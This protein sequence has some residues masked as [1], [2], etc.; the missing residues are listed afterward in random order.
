MKR[1]VLVVLLLL[2]ARSEAAVL[3]VVGG[4]LLGASSV[5]IDGV[6]YDV[7][8]VDG[9]CPDLFSGCDAASDFG[10]SSS[11]TAVLFA[12]ALRDQI[13]IDG[14]QGSFDSDP[15]LVAGCGTGEDQC[16][17]IIPYGVDSANSLGVWFYNNAS[18]ADTILTGPASTPFG[19]ETGDPFG[20]GITWARWTLHATPAVP[21]VS[22]AASLA[23]LALLAASGA[24]AM[25]SAR[26]A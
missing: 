15:G 7:E 2:A 21:S 26:R 25:R 24:W 4:Q 20:D 8:F 13:L 12:E 18:S 14:P 10:T 19:F 22:P 5:D 23:L 17:F 1:V 9:Q 3:N 16:I 6:L 11:A